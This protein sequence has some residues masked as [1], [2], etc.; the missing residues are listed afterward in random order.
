MNLPAGP[1]LWLTHFYRGYSLTLIGG[2]I[3]TVW[4]FVDGL[5][6]G[7]V[8]AWLYDWLEAHLPIGVLRVES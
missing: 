2:A 3:G 7:A 6:G 5:I 4:A 8:F 1:L